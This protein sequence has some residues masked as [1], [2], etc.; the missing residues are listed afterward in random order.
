VIC[1][2]ISSLFQIVLAVAL[3]CTV[4]A[5]RQS[6]VVVAANSNSE[7]SLH[8]ARHYC[9]L[10]K[11]PAWQLLSLS[12]ANPIKMSDAEFAKLQEAI[13]DS[14]DVVAFSFDV[15]YRLGKRSVSAALIGGPH[16]WYQ[17]RIPFEREVDLGR[18]RI[19]PSTY[20]SAH[21]V[22]DAERMLSDAQVHYR[23]PK[24]AGSF[25]FC[26]GVGPRGLRNPQ[27]KSG[28]E[29]VRSLGGRAVLTPSHSLADK[30]DILWQMTGFPRL[31]LGDGYLPG[32][33]VDNMTS[34]GGYLRD[35]RSQSTVH[36]FIRAGASGGYGCVYEP[37]THWQRFAN[38]AHAA[39]YLSGAPLF[40]A[41]LRSVLDWEMGLVVGD[42][43]MAPFAQPPTLSVKSNSAITPVMNLKA[44]LLLPKAGY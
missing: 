15:P 35:P 38:S 18:R 17:S 9:G 32:S 34:L 39:H 24:E 31:T 40:E 26:T 6:R 42:P 1:R 30:S 27:N 7:A 4:H 28:I 3:S 13:P 22:R 20:L 8:I 23:S 10:R 36:D 19:L 41:Y 2:R 12:F 21:N 14:A 29:L 43:L 37:Y 44:V 5:R 25:Y 16:P 33:V 11:L